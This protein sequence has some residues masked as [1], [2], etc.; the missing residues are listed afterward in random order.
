MRQAGDALAWRAAL[1]AATG[2]GP[3][4]VDDLVADLR[5]SA[6]IARGGSLLEGLVGSAVRGVAADTIAALAPGLHPRDAER[7]LEGMD[8]L[9]SFP[10]TDGY[11][12]AE[13]VI[14]L[15][16]FLELRRRGAARGARAWRDW[17]EAGGF[18][19]APAEIDDVDPA[20]VDWNELLRRVNRAFDGGERAAASPE[21]DLLEE[22]VGIYSVG[23]VRESFQKTQESLDR[24]RAALRLA[25]GTAG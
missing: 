5:L 4:A 25:A 18:R 14:Q 22:A 6:L 9:P 17:I 15:G 24:A 1:R 21:T 23:R 19:E 10:S 11:L 20:A 16:T 13:R 12:E 8:V 2:R 7:A 3:E